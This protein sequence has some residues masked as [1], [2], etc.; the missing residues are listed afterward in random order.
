MSLQTNLF[1]L[2]D[3]E[4]VLLEQIFNFDAR[5][6]ETSTS[7]TDVPVTDAGD[8]E[9][10][11]LPTSEI[12]ESVIPP[13]SP[14][15]SLDHGDVCQTLLLMGERDAFESTE[16]F[17][18]ST[19]TVDSSVSTEDGVDCD[20]DI[21][22]S[23]KEAFDADAVL[24]A[25]SPVSYEMKELDRYF[26]RDG[27]ETREVCHLFMEV[28]LLVILMRNKKHRFQVLAAGFILRRGGSA[29]GTLLPV[30]MLNAI[31][32]D[33]VLLSTTTS[34]DERGLF[35]PVTSPTRFSANVL[36][37][38]F[39]VLCNKFFRLASVEDTIAFYYCALALLDPKK[40]SWPSFKQDLAREF[41]L[42]VTQLKIGNLEV[43]C[44]FI[45]DHF[46]KFL[47]VIKPKSSVRL[48][49]RYPK[50]CIIAPPRR[51]EDEKKDP[52]RRKNMKRK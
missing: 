51:F 21:I 38:V 22:E 23:V 25:I 35:L 13:S 1:F 10:V 32:L 19:L 2:E 36:V 4:E 52:R 42:K 46:R 17:A 31:I 39:T 43:L 3:G 49:S 15:S 44:K 30:Y 41:R 33:L 37:R 14:S 5:E 16:N 45:D 24:P 34:S 11:S 40:R 50:K 8:F 29:R 28:I 7:L 47:I 20:S 6:Y 18:S 26:L 12:E 9:E 48:P 27:G